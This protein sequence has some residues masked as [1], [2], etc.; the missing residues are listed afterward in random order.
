MVMLGLALIGCGQ[1]SDQPPSDSSSVSA[2]LNPVSTDSPADGGG[3]RKQFPPIT[4]V[5]EHVGP[6]ECL[7][8]GDW[9]AVDSIPLYEAAGDTTLRVTWI[10]PGAVFSAQDGAIYVAQTGAVVVERPLTLNFPSGRVVVP[11]GDTVIILHDGE[12]GFTNVWYDGVTGYVDGRAWHDASAPSL[13]RY[14]GL[15][16]RR[17]VAVYWVQATYEGQDGWFIGDSPSYRYDTPTSCGD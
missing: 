1:S 12:E 9:T 17:P 2:Q 15:V 11:I 3:L 14:R 6:G 7:S 13:D 16:V 10:P 5:S 4:Y 8:Y